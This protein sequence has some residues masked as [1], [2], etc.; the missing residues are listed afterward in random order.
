MSNYAVRV[1]HLGKEY[2]IGGS[3]QAY[4]TLRDTI[5][6][7]FRGPIRRARSLLRGDI[8]GVAELHETIWALKDV[9]FDVQHGEV[10]GIIGR[11]G[12]GKST[13]LKVLSRITAPTEGE[14][15]LRGR[16]GSLL[17]VGTGFHH[18]LTGR[19][20]IY[21]NG[22]VLGMSHRDIDRK[23][24]E[25]IDFSGLERFVDTPVKHY[26]SGMALRLGFA[27]AAH[28]EPEIL[29]VDEVLA[30]GDAEFQ[31]K[32]VG[33]MSNAASEGRTVLFVSHNMVAVQEL[34]TK[35]ILLE[36]GRIK[37]L[38]GTQ[39]VINEYLSATKYTGE[40]DLSQHP[41]TNGK[42]PLIRHLQLM[43]DGS[44]TNVFQ[45]YKTFKMRV[46]CLLDAPLL[47]AS[48]LGFVVKDAFG[49]VVFTSHS[50]QYKTYAANEVT[51]AVFEASIQQLPLAPGLYSVSLYLTSERVEYDRIENEIF[52]EVIW[53]E[54]IE[55]RYPPRQQWGPIF[56]PVEWDIV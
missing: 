25:I 54:N 24:D 32:C 48:S 10:V 53:N 14:V 52:F 26:S 50:N 3:L 43:A 19:E 9:N 37:L 41:R 35:G 46:E 33:K 8:Y 34:C 4:G 16:V 51:T 31:K 20:N 12:A 42:R 29:V 44:T 55:L 27:V 13:L 28:L 40:L 6:D 47:R 56:V 17:E 15:R 5:V 2:K 49:T 22:A 1:R 7:V 18:E 30:V 39:E 23:F 36:K 11:N 45:T 38:G 21:L